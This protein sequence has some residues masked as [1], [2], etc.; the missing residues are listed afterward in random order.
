MTDKIRVILTKLPDGYAGADEGPLLDANGKVL[1]GDNGKPAHLITPDVLKLESP[2]G[3]PPWRGR[4]LVSTPMPPE[5]VDGLER[6]GAK[7]EYIEPQTV[8]I[9]GVPV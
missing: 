5:F 9:E 6:S 1:V 2:F 4:L 7:W 8:E 3:G